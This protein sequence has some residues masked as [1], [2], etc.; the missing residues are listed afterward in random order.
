LPVEF[1]TPRR[2]EIFREAD[3]DNVVSFIAQVAPATDTDTDLYTVPANKRA[4]FNIRIAERGGGA[5]TIR[6]GIRPLGAALANI[7]YIAYDVAF[8]ANTTFVY[9]NITLSATG[10]VTVRANTA[11]FTFTAEGTEVDGL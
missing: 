8:S 10:V 4:N 9:E 3:R 5:G 11:N 2:E 6:I 7:H 1:P